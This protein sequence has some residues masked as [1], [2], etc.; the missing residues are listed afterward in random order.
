MSPWTKVLDGGDREDRRQLLPDS[1]HHRGQDVDHSTQA[2]SSHVDAFP[3]PVKPDLSAEFT[4]R[5]DSGYPVRRKA[6]RL[7]Y[8]VVILNFPALNLPPWISQEGT[9]QKA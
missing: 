4:P 6:T 3:D 2:A 8:T 1:D 5:P 9:T 7:S